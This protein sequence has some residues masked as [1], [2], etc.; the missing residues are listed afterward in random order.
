MLS[1]EPA[2]A[3]LW[4]DNIGVNNVAYDPDNIFAKILRGEI[5]AVR[6]Y[7]DDQTLAFM[8]V[9]PQSPGHTLVIPKKP[10]RN[11]FDLD[12]VAGLDAVVFPAERHG[13][14]IGADQAAV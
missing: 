3:E 4:T 11:L 6:V 9:M 13:I 12:P 5:P 1:P 10:A 7:E 14:G 8:D 2:V